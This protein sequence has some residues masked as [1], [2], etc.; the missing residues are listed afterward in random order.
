MNTD[1]IMQNKLRA[2]FWSPLLLVYSNYTFVDT[3]E[4]KKFDFVLASLSATGA[5]YEL[6]KLCSTLSRQQ[7]ERVGFHQYY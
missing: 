1:S 7:L 2:I 5:I 6:H 3:T 4:L